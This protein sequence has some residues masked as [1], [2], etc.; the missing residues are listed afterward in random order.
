MKAIIIGAG[1]AGP[2]AALALKRAGVEAEI[3]ERRVST[4]AD[5]GLFLT[6]SVN[7]LR[8]LERLQLLDILND[9]DSIPT[10]TLAFY[11]S[12][13]KRLGKIPNGY[14]K[15]GIPSITVSRGALHAALAARA[16]AEGIPIH[17]GKHLAGLYDGDD[18][19]A[20]SFNDETHAEGDI[21]IGADGIGSTVRR[22]LGLE[23][24]PNETGLL[25]L[26]GIVSAD[27]LAPTPNEM[28]MVWGRRAFFGYTVRANGEAW[29]FAN[30]GSRK[31]GNARKPPPGHAWKEHLLKL[32]DQ[33]PPHIRN[34]ISRTATEL[35]AYPIQDMPSLPYWHRGRSVLIGDAAHAVSPSSGQGASLA[36]ED[37]ITLARCLRDTQKPRA[38]FAQFENLR[39]QRTE[40]IIAEGRKRGTYKAMSNPLAIALRDLAM[41]LVFRFLVKEESFAWILNHDIA[42]DEPVTAGAGGPRP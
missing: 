29:W 33:D 8:V 20:V 23:I 16:E 42:W 34:M 7:G 38:A 6:V 10:P 35:R 41:P 18:M 25:N 9:L 27:D 2:V 21:L 17:Y 22:H 30:I 5:T 4:L 12:T 11:S 15:P 13:G 1:I 24:A 37:A 14:L 40:R 32:F 36:M 39:R 28:R 3:F 31:P 19:V 26:G